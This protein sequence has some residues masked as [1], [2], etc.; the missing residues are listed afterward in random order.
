MY[1]LCECV[2]L[3]LFGVHTQPRYSLDLGTW[4]CSRLASAGLWHSAASA[5]THTTTPM[6]GFRKPT[7]K[8]RVEVKAICIALLEGPSQAATALPL[9]ASSPASSSLGR[10]ALT[11]PTEVSASQAARCIC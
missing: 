6:D 4:Q 3:C 7:L 8:T 9:P 2:Q 5:T 1:T 11:G 10:C